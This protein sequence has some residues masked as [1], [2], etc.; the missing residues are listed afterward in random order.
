MVNKSIKSILENNEDK[1]KVCMEINTE[2]FFK[3]LMCCE[4]HTLNNQKGGYMRIT[5]L[6]VII[7]IGF[8]GQF[9][10]KSSQ[11]NHQAILF[12]AKSNAT[13]KGYSISFYD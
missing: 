1:V 3:I 10:K 12:R 8:L 7:T 2:P 5:S 13:E 9:R 6:I 4:H 11:F